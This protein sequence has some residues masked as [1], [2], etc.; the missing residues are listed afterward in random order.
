LGGLLGLVSKFSLVRR[1]VSGD[2]KGCVLCPNACPTGTIAPARNYASDPGECTMCLECL[3][4]CPRG[5]TR[6]GLPGSLQ[7][8]FSKQ[9][10][11]AYDPGRR[12]ALYALGGAATAVALL[13]SDLSA[14]KVHP[15]RLRP[16]GVTEENLL[17]RC[18]RCAECVRACP[19]AALQPALFEAGVEGLWTPL[20]IPRA[21]YCDYSCNACGQVCPVQAIPSLDLVSKREQVV[22]KAYIDQNR[23]IAWAD[24]IDCIV[25]E[26]M[27]PLP[28]KAIHLRIAE[29]TG[30]HGEVTTVQLPEVDRQR[31]I[32][33]GICEYKC[34]LAGE[35]AIRIY[36]PEAQVS[37]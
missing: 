34:P 21:G 33:C 27:C 19:T 25:C 20:L 15:H 17:A 24:G 6:F 12:Q 22:G 16:P 9:A 10:W 35:A 7:A 3:Q 28:D 11:S 1:Q 18:V 37:F 32:G 2:C 36:V 31:C 4:A 13:G 30:L 26:E 29:R 8:V 23:C 5:A 14:V